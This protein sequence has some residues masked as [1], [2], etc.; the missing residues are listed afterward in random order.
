MTKIYT[1][2]DKLIIDEPSLNLK[3]TVEK[4]K[5][6]LRGANLREAYLKGVNLEGAILGWDDLLGANLTEAYLKGANLSKADLGEGYF[7]LITATTTKN[8]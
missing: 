8:N 3:E 7:R 4:H 5:T 6:N 1:L 2:D